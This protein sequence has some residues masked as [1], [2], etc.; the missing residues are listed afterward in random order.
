MDLG[1]YLVDPGGYLMDPRGYL[2]DRGGY[3]MDP[4][5]YLGGFWRCLCIYKHYA[6]AGSFVIEK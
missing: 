4:G 2:V 6:S 5:G 3:L 1:G